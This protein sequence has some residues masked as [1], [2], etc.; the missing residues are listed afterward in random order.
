MHSKVSQAW[1]SLCNGLCVRVYERRGQDAYERRATLQ[2]GSLWEGFQDGIHFL[3][4]SCEGKLK[5]VLYRQK[6]IILYI[7]THVH[8]S[9]HKY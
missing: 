4:H 6:N 2:N 9:L 8:I 1:F 3:C 5:L 7:H